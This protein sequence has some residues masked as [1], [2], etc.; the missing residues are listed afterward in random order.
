MR[1]IL[2]AIGGD[3]APEQTVAGA[4]EAARELNVE[5]VLLGPEATVRAELAKHATAGLRLPIV[6]APELIGMDEHP[7]QA[8][9]RKKNS[10]VAVGLRMVRDGQADAFVS[11]GHSGATLAGAVFILGRAPGIE[12][13][14]L[15]SIFPTVDGTMVVADMGA[16]TD[17]KPEYLLQFARMTSLY[18]QL[19]LGIE[20]PRVAL[21]SNGEED[22]KG[23]K[24]V[25][26]AHAL[27]HGSE[28][29]FVGNAEP[30]DALVGG[31]A[32]VLV[33][34]GFVGNLFIKT[35]EAVAKFAIEK[36]R[37]ELR[38]RDVALRAVAG[39]LPAAV[40]IGLSKD[41]LRTL[42]AALMGGPVVLGAVLVPALRRMAKTLDYRAYGGA[43]LLGVGGVTIVAHG[44]SDAAAIVSAIRRAKESVDRGLVEAISSAVSA[45]ANGKV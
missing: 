26:D 45:S 12:R 32:D 25:Q 11:A 3:R 35:A 1:I 40:L 30:K 21:L 16:T 5:I 10:S 39:L 38:G 18:A 15:A 28:L 19:V 22:S 31:I 37:R 24:L 4:V 13:P 27:L 41:R 34:D 2:D 9:R 14:C 36:L 44:K 6:D 42:L 20:R 8:I 29:N 17:S 33:A 7:V 43:P 23:D